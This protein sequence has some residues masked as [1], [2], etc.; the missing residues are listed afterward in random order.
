V[1][2]S[3]IYSHIKLLAGI[4]RSTTTSNPLSFNKGRLNGP[5]GFLIHSL[6]LY[7]CLIHK[8]DPKVQTILMNFIHMF[9]DTD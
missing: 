3:P 2:A 6:G 7:F 8:L 4:Y 9:I 5:I 1:T